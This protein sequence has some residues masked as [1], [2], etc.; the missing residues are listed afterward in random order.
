MS[1]LKLSDFEDGIYAGLQNQ[2]NPHMAG[3]AQG[4]E[5][6][7]CHVS[8]DDVNWSVYDGSVFEFVLAAGSS[9][10]EFAF[11]DAVK[12][13]DISLLDDYA[14]LDQNEHAY[15]VCV[16][17]DDLMI[18]SIFVSDMLHEVVG[19]KFGG[20]VSSTLALRQLIIDRRAER[21][22]SLKLTSK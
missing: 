19:N 18:G 5:K 20:Q 1:L 13:E 2:K 22:K 10:S 9:S 3:E 17:M 15:I 21:M 7:I 4:A 12:A 11:V 14:A 16:K 6:I 8:L